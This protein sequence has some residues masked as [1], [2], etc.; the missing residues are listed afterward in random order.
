MK[1]E[2]ST[3]E[4]VQEMNV[5]ST[6]GVKDIRIFV[7]D[8]DRYGSVIADM[9]DFFSGY[10]QSQTATLSNLCATEVVA[11][12]PM[13]DIAIMGDLIH[14]AEM[15]TAGEYTFL[16]DF[17]KLPIAIKSKLKKG[18][19]TIG[20]SKQVDGNWRPV[21]LDENGVR[22]KDITLKRVL[23]NPDALET[24]RNIANQMQMRQIYA[25]LNEIQEMQDY[26]IDIQRNQ[27]I[28]VPF[29]NART[30]ILDAQNSLTIEEQQKH[31]ERAYDYLDTAI[32]GLYADMRSVGDRLVKQIRWPLFQNRKQI[33][34]FIGFITTDLQLASKFVGVHLQVCEH[35]GRPDSAANCL[36]RYR[37]NMKS[38]CNTS[39]NTKRQTLANIVHLY[40]PY[41]EKNRDFWLDFSEGIIP[42]LDKASCLTANSE[43]YL[44]STEDDHNGA[45]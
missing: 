42:A 26:Q 2:K 3:S 45:E 21:I 16:P 11:S 44:V 6:T 10:I 24:S 7:T 14:H 31:L 34:T 18:L 25:K 33:Q 43:I 5:L 37:H 29:L 30:A 27:A 23:S 32:N 41:T 22:V 28:V 17:D 1:N 39:V 36:E 20:K 38:F 19:Y 4:Q 40:F 15:L 13:A 8:A 12:F 9:S 35:L